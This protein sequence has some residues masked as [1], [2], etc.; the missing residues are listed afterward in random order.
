LVLHQNS[1]IFVLKILTS[2]WYTKFFSTIL[3]CEY[4]KNRTFSPAAEFF[5]W[6]GAEKFRQELATECPKISRI[7]WRKTTFFSLI[8][9]NI[10][11]TKKPI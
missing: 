7:L 8:W 10:L 6:S 3:H 11:H 1:H 5:G 2:H 4:L 9:M